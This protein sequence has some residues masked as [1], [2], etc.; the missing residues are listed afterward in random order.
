MSIDPSGTT[1]VGE[2]AA[3]GTALCWV[4]SSIGFEVAGKRCGALTLNMIRLSLGLVGLTLYCA[5]FVGQW[6][7]TDAS[8]H[9][10]GWL[11]ASAITGFLIGDYCL[12]RALIAIGSRLSTLVMS[13]TPLWTAAIGW[14]LLDE[15]LSLR[16]MGAVVL[17][18]GG[19]AWAVSDQP[20]TETIHRPRRMMLGLVF[21][22][23]AAIGQAAGLVMSKLGMGD[24]DAVVA[25]QIRV[26]I[27]VVGNICVCTILGWW[28]RVFRAVRSREVML[29]TAVGTAFGPF[30]GV[31]LSLLAVQLARNTGVA[32]ALMGI[33]PILI[34]PIV[35]ARGEPVGVGGWIGAIIA[36]AGVTLLFLGA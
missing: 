8:A 18:L 12:F 10:W 16:D 6:F 11:S 19:I 35:R 9:M 17:V 34:I 2:L 32:A 27:A 23:L 5:V 30:L 21:A 28:T 15:Q 26:G 14:L 1:Q 31:V 22:T 4:L 33:A 36:V 24:A 7:P 3:L 13:S 25:S 29:P 20:K